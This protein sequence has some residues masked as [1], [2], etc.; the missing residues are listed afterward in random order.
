NDESLSGIDYKDHAVM[1]S[2]GYEYLMGRH[3]WLIELHQ[4]E[5]LLKTDN[6]FSKPSHE[7]FLGY[8]YYLNNSAI[9]FTI[10]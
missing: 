3:G 2:L 9:E 4:Y 8:R 6:D 5:G 10:V 1:L 7:V